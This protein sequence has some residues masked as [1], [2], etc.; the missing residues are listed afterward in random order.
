MPG[1]ETSPEN[2]G[3][4]ASDIDGAIGRLEAARRA[5]ADAHGDPSAFG[6]SDEGVALGA[7]WNAAVDARQREVV[8]AIA[9]LR[10]LRAGLDDSRREYEDAERDNSETVGAVEGGSR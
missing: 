4:A 10:D 5:L 8:E 3:R 6:A 7:K 1:F 9:M 2:L